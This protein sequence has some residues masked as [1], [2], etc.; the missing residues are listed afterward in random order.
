ML[1]QLKNLGLS[2]NEA[3][4]Y[5]AMLELGPATMLEISAKAGINRPTAYV[6]IEAL[7]K[8]GLVSTQVRGKKTYF[9]AESPSQLEVVLE[10]EAKD[11]EIKQEELA[12]ILPALT[13]L[14][15][16]GDTK[17]VVRFFEGIEGLRKMQDECL[18]SKEK[19][20]YAITSVDD[21]LRIFPGQLSSYTPRR[22]AKGIYAQ[23]IYTSANGP[24]LAESDEKM[25]R[26]SRYINSERL[27]FS[28]DVTIFDD[29]VAITSMRGK[30]S[31][32]I[33]TH[34]EI[35]ESFKGLFRFLWGTADRTS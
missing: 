5:V 7:K 27:P 2:D 25:L 32:V 4:T 13:T 16:L 19:R 23:T 20:L 12:K 15:S 6:Q 10:K 21:V 17:P 28:A 31:G 30:L 11:V 3:K 26:Q 35:A 22:V 18:K 8:L 34:K 33:I 9:M 29:N 14:F 1:N 24:V